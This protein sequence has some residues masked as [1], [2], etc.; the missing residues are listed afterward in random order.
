[1]MQGA[2]PPSSYKS[3][4]SDGVGVGREVQKGRDIC[5]RMAD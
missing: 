1:M 2:Q 5:I 4:G 3:E